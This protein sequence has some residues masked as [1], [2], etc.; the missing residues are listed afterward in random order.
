MNPNW[1]PPGL[2]GWLLII[3]VI[4]IILYLLGHRVIVS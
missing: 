3:A 4:L 1:N 2:L